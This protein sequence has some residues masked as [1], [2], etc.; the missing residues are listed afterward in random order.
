MK[1]SRN[2]RY[3]CKRIRM[4]QYRII[5]DYDFS[6]VNKYTDNIPKNTIAIYTLKKKNNLK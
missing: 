3:I 1:V 6:Y 2:F 4:Y 5:Y